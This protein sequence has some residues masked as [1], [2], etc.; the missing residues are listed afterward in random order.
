M[1]DRQRTSGAAGDGAGEQTAGVD[2][3]HDV[4]VAAA[5]GRHLLGGGPLIAGADLQVDD[6]VERHREATVAIEDMGGLGDR[7]DDEEAGHWSPALV[8]HSPANAALAL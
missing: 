6:L 7:A 4:D 8:D 2:G 1:V 5:G 3:Q